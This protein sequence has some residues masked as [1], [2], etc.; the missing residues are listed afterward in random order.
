MGT[1]RRAVRPQ[2]VRPCAARTQHHTPSAVTAD[3]RAYTR[4][5]AGRAHRSIP[6]ST[7]DTAHVRTYQYVHRKHAVPSRPRPLPLSPPPNPRTQIAVN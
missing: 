3:V 7:C 5:R 2:A 4:L 6:T 1:S